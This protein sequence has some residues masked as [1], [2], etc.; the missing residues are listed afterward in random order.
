MGSSAARLMGTVGAEPVLAAGIAAVGGAGS[1]RS[2]V[3]QSWSQGD[4]WASP[5]VSSCSRSWGQAV[6][7]PRSRFPPH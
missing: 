7:L 3:A 1:R 2:W 4:V 5:P 6:N